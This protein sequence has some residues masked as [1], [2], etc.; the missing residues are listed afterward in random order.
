MDLNKGRNLNFMW[1]ALNNIPHWSTVELS[2]KFL[3]NMGVTTDDVN[4][5][6]QFINPQKILEG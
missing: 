6:E 3:T 4:C 5:F 2:L 1:M